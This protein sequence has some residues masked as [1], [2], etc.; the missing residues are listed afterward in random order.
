MQSFCQLAPSRNDGLL[1]ARQS[2]SSALLDNGAIIAGRPGALLSDRGKYDCLTA[3]TEVR[4]VE[5]TTAHAGLAEQY[6]SQERSSAMKLS[7]CILFECTGYVG[8]SF[9]VVML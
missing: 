1:A 8:G 7:R 2:V 6:R 4:R 9:N 3:E 5:A